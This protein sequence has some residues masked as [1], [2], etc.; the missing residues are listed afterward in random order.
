MAVVVCGKA[1]EAP[2]VAIR[3]AGD[4]A[5]SLL[6]LFSILLFSPAARVCLLVVQVVVCDLS[7]ACSSCLVLLQTAEEVKFPC[8]DSPNVESNNSGKDE[9]HGEEVEGCEESGLEAE[10]S[11]GRDGDESC[12]EEG[13]NVA[14]RRREN[15]DAG[16]S[17]N[18]AHL[19]L[20][21]KR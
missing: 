9:K 3:G 4:V 2:L 5:P 16:L 15:G 21:E 12:G 18:L 17:K 13:G 1:G 11:E 7:Q 8:K 6:P 19:V 14:N 20:G 10:R